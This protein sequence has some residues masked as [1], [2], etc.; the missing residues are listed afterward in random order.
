[1]GQV[2]K[3]GDYLFDQRIFPDFAFEVI[4]VHP[5][6]R[7]V[8]ITSSTSIRLIGVKRKPKWTVEIKSNV[9][10][11][12]IIGL[13]HVKRK[14]RIIMKYLENPE[15]FG[16]WAP[17]NILFYGQPGTG[18]TMTAKALANTTNVPL[19]LIRATDLIGEHVGEGAKRIHEVFSAAAENAPAVVF[20]DELD[21][22][23]LDRYY[24]NLR[25]DVAEVVNALLTEMDGLA[26][27]KGVVTIGA[28]N[29]PTML[30]HAIRNRFE[31]EIDFPLPSRKERLDMMEYYSKTL[32]LPV[33]ASL[34][35]YLEATDGMSGRD[36]KERLLKNALHKAIIEGSQEVNDEHLT[37]ALSLLENTPQNKPPKNMFA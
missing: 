30:D 6:E 37:H 5:S 32:P 28:T 1:M 23:A 9:T 14:C 3:K 16:E 12:D 2:V 36:I 31:E 13:D 29:N 35:R 27:N 20:I 26:E 15:V 34:R 8:R 19:Y 33:K 4:E 24:Q 10:F 25:G 18:K 21:A 22:I 7:P 17:R 11:N